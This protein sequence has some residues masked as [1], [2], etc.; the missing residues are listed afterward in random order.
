VHI[1]QHEFTQIKPWT[2]F[3]LGSV[4]A[5]SH[6]YRHDGPETIERLGRLDELVRS[7]YEQYARLVPDFDVVVFSDHGHI[8]VE[9]Q[10]DLQA[11]F[12]A[13]GSNLFKFINLVEA[14]YA[15]FWFRNEQER[16]A[17]ERILSALPDGCILSA[18]QMEKN[19]VAMPDNRY[20]DLVFY[21]DR[22][23]IF[24]KTIWGFGRKQ[25]SMHGYLTEYPESDGI[26]LSQRALLPGTHVDLVD[27]LPTLLSSLGLPIPGYVDGRALWAD[28]LKNPHQE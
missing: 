16:A 19:H 11:H 24:S 5:F 12:R 1:G 27:V 15:R 4:D 20:G 28:A 10:V 8:P 3:F 22:P 7:K 23:A 21:L 17:V 18:A 2:Y 6:R 13:H 14:N 26:F 25:K 9:K